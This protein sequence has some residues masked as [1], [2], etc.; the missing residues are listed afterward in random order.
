MNIIGFILDALLL[1]DLLWWWRADRVLRRLPRAQ[2]WRIALGL[3]MAAQAVGLFLVHTSRR[4]D[5]DLDWLL[6][7]PWLTCIYL[8]HCLLLLPM[9]LLWIPYA[10][11]KGTVAGV[12]ALIRLRDA[13]HP[14]SAANGTRITRREF[15]RVLATAAPAL[16]T[17]G[18]AGVALWQLERF[19]I[20]RFDI[21]LAGLPPALDGLTIAHVTDFHVGQFTRGAVLDRIVAATNA[22]RAD[23]VLFTG[24]LINFA[25]SDLEAALGVATRL[26]GAHGVFLCEGNHDLFEN[27]V[28]F[29]ARMRVAGLR[30]LV[31]ESATVSIRG[32][33]VLLLGLRWGAR[34]RPAH[35]PASRGDDAIAESMREL[36]LQR[37]QGAFPI[38]LAH[39]P[40]A[41]DFAGDIPLTLAG[42]THGGQI[43]VTQNV[44][45]GPMLYRYWS[46]LYRAGKR[47]LLV[48]NGTGN[49][50]PLR[51]RAPA[52]IL[53][54]TLRHG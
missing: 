17:L 12:R 37:E 34:D 11:A 52:E 36:L 15:A 45:F 48:S 39:H 24:D 38:L 41:F 31:N 6:N 16:T 35:D 46:G 26:R 10:L 14:P 3:F 51:T 9:L 5:L 4:L 22:L 25:L 1:G 50:F 28:E 8:W 53:H 54:I 23:L 32:V 19:R 49:W 7:G 30:L 21:A 47:A 44:G 18:A 33:D 43:M 27:P 42:H 40:H 2:P 20:R 13:R 29:R